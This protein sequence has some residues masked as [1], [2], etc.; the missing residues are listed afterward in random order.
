M[1]KLYDII[2]NNS[3]GKGESA[4]WKSVDIMS[5]FL[6][7]KLSEHD[8]DEL[9]S[10]L[11]GVMSGGH[12]DETFAHNEV[13]KMYYIDRNNRKHS[14]PYW[15][16]GEVHN[17]YERVRNKISSQ[18]TFY[19]FYVTFNM[20]ASDNWCLYTSWWPDIKNEELLVKFCESTVN[21]LSDEDWPTT[22]KIW[23]YFHK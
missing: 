23:D 10:K 1:A 13:K 20:I 9:S 14:A 8:M 21:W 17:M 19:D 7:D 3:T 6:D 16:E 15:T 12:Y 11:F 5:E 18:Y 4:M 22:S 2:K